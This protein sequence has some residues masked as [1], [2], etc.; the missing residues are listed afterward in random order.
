MNRNK[1]IILSLLNSFLFCI[2][3]F[4]IAVMMLGC[5]KTEIVYKDKIVEVYVP[6]PQKCDYT[7]S[8]EP[9]LDTSSNENLLNSLTEL[10][11]DSV[12]LRKEIKNIPCLNIK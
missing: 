2:V 3:V 7:L 10:S 8:K 12:K 4:L 9:S 5:T 11:Y 1:Q 6:T